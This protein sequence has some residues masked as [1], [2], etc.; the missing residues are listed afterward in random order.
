MNVIYEFSVYYV[1]DVSFRETFHAAWADRVTQL[2]FEALLPNSLGCL[3]SCA[4]FLESLGWIIDNEYVFSE[5]INIDDLQTNMLKIFF[6]RVSKIMR[7]T[8]SHFIY[9]VRFNSY[10]YQCMNNASHNVLHLFLYWFNSFIHISHFYVGYRCLIFFNFS[11]LS[12]I[13]LIKQDCRRRKK[14]YVTPYIV[15]PHLWLNWVTPVT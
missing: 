1:W 4:G 7:N 5:Y 2:Q 14:W 8:T 11:Y 15:R 9:E 6:P 3:L 12:R 10:F 13:F